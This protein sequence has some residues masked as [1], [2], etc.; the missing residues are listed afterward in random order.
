MD[1]PLQKGVGCRYGVLSSGRPSSR[2]IE[3]AMLRI[4]KAAV[5]GL[6]VVFHWD[7]YW[8]GLEPR[9]HRARAWALHLSALAT[10]K[11]G[12]GKGWGGRD[13]YGA[14][15]SVDRP[16]L[17]VAGSARLSKNMGRERA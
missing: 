5:V 3:E 8:D 2:S 16:S 13:D 4:V 6:D 15:A 12:H 7:V 11:A 14:T 17:D 9:R 10:N 1:L